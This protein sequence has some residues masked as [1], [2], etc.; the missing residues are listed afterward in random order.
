MADKIPNILG[1]K[2][3][4]I[5]GPSLAVSHTAPGVKKPIKPN[6]FTPSELEYGRE[7]EEV[8]KRAHTDK[9]EI[10]VAEPGGDKD[11]EVFVPTPPD[12]R[13]FTSTVVGP[14]ALAR[15]VEKIYKLVPHLRG[16]SQEIIMGPNRAVMESMDE[17]NTLGKLKGKNRWGPENYESAPMLG[18]TDRSPEGENNISL[19]P[20]HNY[21]DFRPS[22]L[23]NTVA[24]ELS[25]VAGYG[26]PD[27]YR[28]GDLFTKEQN[29]R[30]QEEVNARLKEKLDKIKADVIKG[31][32]R[33]AQ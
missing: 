2:S 26:H 9:D 31:G 7:V 20:I 29:D 11:S 4:N 14:P 23:D 30:F 21:G 16:V 32:I 22:E 18:V 17:Q 5:F 13:P 24:H 3:G 1:L 10:Y 15:T 33:M 8:A 28:L 19:N 25:H 6:I 27:A 12:F